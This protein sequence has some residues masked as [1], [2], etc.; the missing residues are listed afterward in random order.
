MSEQQATRDT[1]LRT[2]INTVEKI[3][4]E[5]Y[6]AVPANLVKQLLLR[7]GDLAASDGDL[8]RDLEKLVDDILKQES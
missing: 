2:L 5:K 1:Q 7:H 4:A 6:A 3:R 8:V